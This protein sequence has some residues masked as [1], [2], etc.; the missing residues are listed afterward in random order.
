MVSTPVVIKKKED[1]EKKIDFFYELKEIV[2]SWTEVS[3]DSHF[4][5]F[6]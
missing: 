6:L 3:I 1:S 2:N 4:L 5:L